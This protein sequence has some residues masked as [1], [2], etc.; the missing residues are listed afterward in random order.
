MYNNN[1]NLFVDNNN[2]NLSTHSQKTF[3]DMHSKNKSI[4][5]MLSNNDPKNFTMQ[6]NE[7]NCN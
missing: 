5:Q 1:K 2:H 4:Q 7:S 3:T 6:S